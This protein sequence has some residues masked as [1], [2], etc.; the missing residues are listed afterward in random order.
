[1][2]FWNKVEYDRI[3]KKLEH[4]EQNKIDDEKI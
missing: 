1:M 3:N 4:A 2:N